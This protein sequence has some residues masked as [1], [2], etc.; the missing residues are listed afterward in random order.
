M[1]LK[2]NSWTKI[3]F[4]PRKQFFI[5][6]LFP[7][8]KSAECARVYSLSRLHS[9]TQTR[10]TQQDSSDPPDAEN[11]SWQLTHQERER[12]SCPRRN[13]KPQ[14]QQNGLPKNQAK[15]HIAP[16]IG[17]RNTKK[18]QTLRLRQLLSTKLIE[19]S[20]PHASLWSIGRLVTVPCI[21]IIRPSS[22]LRGQSLM[23]GYFVRKV[24]W[25]TSMCH[26]GRI[27]SKYFGECSVRS[28]YPSLTLYSQQL[29]QS[30]NKIFIKNE[31]GG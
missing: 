2:E 15:D 10:H 17:I 6:F 11:S 5:F 29:T 23:P 3:C 28:Y 26:G 16:V 20:V 9:H 31:Q 22:Y 7:W 4:I 8:R 19:I 27:F 1:T 24:W 25:T 13:S 30:L 21:S 14:S 18:Q 12:H